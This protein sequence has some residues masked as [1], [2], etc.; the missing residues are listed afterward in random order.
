MDEHVEEHIEME[1]ILEEQEVV[2]QEDLDAF[3][4]EHSS[5]LFTTDQV[6]EYAQF[7]FEDGSY[8]DSMVQTHS[9]LTK[10]PLK[11]RR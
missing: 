2:L 1:E 9:Q 7:L 11:G 6:F 5:F 3:R 8:K 4:L 10:L